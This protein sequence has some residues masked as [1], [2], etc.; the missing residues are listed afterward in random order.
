MKCKLL[1]III[2]LFVLTGT[3]AWADQYIGLMKVSSP[4]LYE[5]NAQI[6]YDY[7]EQ[8]IKETDA[9][10]LINTSARISEINLAVSEDIDDASALK[11]GKLPGAEFIL[12][13]KL[14]VDEG[15]MFLSA[16]IIS[17]KTGEIVSST[18]RQIEEAEGL[19]F[20]VE[21]VVTELISEISTNPEPPQ[22]LTK[23]VG[24]YQSVIFS[25]YTPY[26]GTTRI[27][28]NSDGKLQG[29]YV[30]IENG[31]EITGIL[32]NFSTFPPQGLKCMW[33]DTYGK[34][35]LEMTFNKDLTQFNGFWSIRGETA[36]FRW[37]GMKQ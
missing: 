13:S 25:N 36:R 12:V 26:P 30:F 33:K 19:D 2:V 18:I 6:I 11:A 4:E 1:S 7:M 10:S 23:T 29:K 17:V 22:W 5:E 34:G 27:V 3:I 21:R 37:N 35:D 9:F 15:N 31:T 8:F 28:L 20:L 32:W 24:T 14:S 16:R